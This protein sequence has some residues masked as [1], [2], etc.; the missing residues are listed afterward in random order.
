MRRSLVRGRSYWF[1]FSQQLSSEREQR[2]GNGL[3]FF[4]PA[5]RQHTGLRF[6]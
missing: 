3:A 1:V 2:A 4:P 6:S 5:N